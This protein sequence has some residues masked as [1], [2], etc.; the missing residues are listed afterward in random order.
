MIRSGNRP[1][2]IAAALVA[3]LVAL[4]PSAATAAPGDDCVATRMI[5]Q[6]NVGDVGTGLTVA[7]GTQPVSFGAEVLGVLENALAPGRDVILVEVSGSVIDAAGG[8]WYGMSG[9]PVFVGGELIGALSL[10]FSGSSRIA[11]LTPA[12]DLL[13]LAELG[14]GSAR[15]AVTLD[16]ETRQAVALRTGT[17][18]GTVDRQLEALA[19]PL[20]VTGVPTRYVD[21]LRERAQAAGAPWVPYAGGGSRTSD[22]LAAGALV[23]GGKMAAMLASGDVAV[24]AS[25]TVAYTCDDTLIGFGHPFMHAGASDF[26]LAQAS[27]LGVVTDPVWGPYELANAGAVVGTIDQDRLAGVR[28]DFGAIPTAVPVT[29]QVTALDTGISRSGRSD[30]YATDLL[31]DMVLNHMLGS[32]YGVF[33]QY[34]QGSAATDLRVVGTA[35]GTPFQYERSNLSASDWDI[36]WES[37][38]PAYADLATLA[39]TTVADV[40]FTSVDVTTSVTENVRRATLSHVDVSYDGEAWFPIDE[41]YLTVAPGGSLYLRASLRLTPGNEEQA[42][43]FVLEVPTDFQGTASLEVI[44]GQ[45]LAFFEDPLLCVYDPAACPD[46]DATF[47]DLLARLAA[48]PGQDELVARLT[49]YQDSGGQEPVPGEEPAFG[50]GG[51]DGSDSPT[52]QVVEVRQRLDRVVTGQAYAS[53][54]VFDTVGPVAQAGVTRIAGANRIATA[55]AASESTWFGSEAVVIAR[56]DDPTDAMVAA[57]LAARLGAPLLLTTTGGLPEEVGDE[58]LRLGA[59][60]AVVVGGPAAVNQ[61]VLDDLDDLGL[62]R[63]ERIAGTDRADT[64]RRVALRLGDSVG[65][66]LVAADAWQDAAAASALAAVQQRP[67]LLAGGTSLPAATGQALDELGVQEVT[68]VGGRSAVPTSVADALED[69]GIEVDRLAG[70]DR[71]ATSLVVAEHA[72]NEAFVDPYQLVIATGRGF[73]DALVAGSLA[74]SRSGV[75][76]LVDGSDADTVGTALGWLDQYPGASVTIVGGT[77][78]VSEDAERALT[79]HLA[80]AAL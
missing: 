1:A 54:D 25:G 40:E 19:V 35:D 44:G 63:V 67:L 28:G 12:Q 17:D 14:T 21:R 10:G 69:L 51:T 43:D 8:V 61:A 16:D 42:V 72:V 70:S 6:V 62:E 59:G 45:D 50:V 26:A 79:D 23:P 2:G 48:R 56:A 4:V 60:R 74:A 36:I 18:V 27:S 38:W 47:D 24:F 3:T 78:A 71:Y 68:I 75:L 33:D 15:T 57:P 31:P 29:S 20:T 73:G 37:Q 32:V 53:V 22:R 30:V 55:I 11:G 64:A 76:L 58:V 66:L 9:S 52:P 41:A 77:S 80:D 7:S 34:S 65:A 46:T 5:D 13:D 49:M 39:A